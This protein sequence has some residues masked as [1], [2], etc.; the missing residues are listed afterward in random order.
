MFAA[1]TAA[2]IVNEKYN[3]FVVYVWC[4][5]FV[6][7]CVCLFFCVFFFGGGGGFIISGN[8]GHVSTNNK[9][10][11]TTISHCCYLELFVFVYYTVA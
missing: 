8:F 7:V 3:V 11:V 2:H 5:F 4:L 9:E 10:S 6:F 1:A